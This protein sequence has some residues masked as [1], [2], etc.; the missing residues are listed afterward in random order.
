MR[1]KRDAEGNNIGRSHHNPIL[2]TR[3]YEVAFSDGH[4]AEYVTN[5]IAENIYSMIDD[6]EGMSTFYSRISLTIGVIE[7]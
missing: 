1:Q 5:V 2:D 4:V 7:R 3:I 6:E